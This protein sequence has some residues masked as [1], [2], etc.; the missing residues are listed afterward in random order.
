MIRI[1]LDCSRLR[2]L[3]V[4]GF[5]RTITGESILP[6]A[7]F[8]PDDNTVAVD[9]AECRVPSY[10]RGNGAHL[11][12]VDGSFDVVT[13]CDT[14]EH[15]PQSLRPA[16]V[17]ELLRVAARY[18]ILAAPFD[19]NLT[20]LADQIIFDFNQTFYNVEQ[21]QLREHI[22]NVLP[23][24]DELRDWI[25]QRGHLYVD[26]ASGYLHHWLPMMLLKHYLFG[27]PDAAH[28]HINL[29]RYYNLN[30]SHRDQRAPAYRHVFVISK[31]KD[32]ET[33]LTKVAQ[34]FQP[35]SNVSSDDGMALA[36]S[37]LTLVEW[38]RE[39]KRERARNRF[40]VLQEQ[41]EQLHEQIKQLQEQ[42]RQLAR[43][44]EAIRNGRVMRLMAGVRQ[45]WLGIT[46]AKERH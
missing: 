5:F 37:L 38:Q 16:F 34:S 36:R 15:V 6:I 17:D 13:T 45:L 22:E 14:L 24:R 20:R 27:L 41:N 25:E 3:D 42:C 43:H 9:L 7:Q 40:M 32:D 8:L 39:F 18:V 35:L 12:F 28:L 1:H 29:D 23:N 10:V 2:V 44:I 11:P 26:F 21:P 33:F 4:G 31:T 30:F 19:D 46:G